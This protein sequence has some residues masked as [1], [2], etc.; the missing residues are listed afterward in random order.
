M[1]EFMNAVAFEVGGAMVA[2]FFLLNLCLGRAHPPVARAVVVR[3][4]RD[5]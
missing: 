3:R 4:Q 2:S 5:D 1:L